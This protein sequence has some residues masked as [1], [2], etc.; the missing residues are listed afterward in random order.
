[1][2]GFVAQL[3]EFSPPAGATLYSVVLEDFTYDEDLLP[4][5]DLVPDRLPHLAEGR[6]VTVTPVHEL[7]YVSQADIT[8]QKL[9]MIEDAKTTVAHVVVP[10]EGEVHFVDTQ[11]FGMGPELSRRAAA[12]PLYRMH[13]SAVMVSPLS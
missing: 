12:A 9:L 8:G 3:G 2:Q 7:G 1:M 5:V 10:L 6:S 13:S 11:T 4:I